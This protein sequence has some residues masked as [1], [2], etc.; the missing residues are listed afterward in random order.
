MREAVIVSTARTAIGKAY[1]GGLNN[2]DSPTMGAFAIR[3]AVRK[4]GID[5]AEIEDCILGAGIQQGSQWMNVARKAAIA[6]DLPVTVSGMT[7]DRQCSSGLMAIATAAKQ[8]AHDGMQ[9]AI[10]GGL[11]SISL[12]QN[13]HMNFFRAE[14]QNVVN[15]SPG[16]RLGMIDTAEIVAQRYKVSR[17]SQDEYALQSQQRTAAAQQAG[18]FADEIVPVSVKWQKTDKATGAVSEDTLVLSADEGPRAGTTLEALSG[19]K[20]VRPEG[21]VTAGNASQLSACWS[22]TVLPSTISGSGS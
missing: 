22:A 15:R 10:G 12:C 4:A 14:D 9:V 3:E 16:S 7:I 18:R 5:P 1:R 13:E 8:I 2:T 17:E 11:E 21:S 20:P 6:A 19:L